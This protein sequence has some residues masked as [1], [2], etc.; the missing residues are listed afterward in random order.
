MPFLSVILI[1]VL[2]SPLIQDGDA[3]SSAIQVKANSVTVSHKGRSAALEG[4]V[5]VVWEGLSVL[6]D[7]ITLEYS[8]NGSPKTWLAQG[9]VRVTWRTYNIVSKTLTIEQSGDQLHFKGPLEFSQGQTTLQA[10]SAVLDLAAKT[11]SAQGV[12]GRVNLSTMTNSP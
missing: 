3:A 5:R 12:Q 4:D 10:R 7:K 9:K 2:S 6:A 1:L 8:D 11:L